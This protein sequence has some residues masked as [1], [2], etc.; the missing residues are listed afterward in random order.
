MS[1]GCQA[2]IAAI[3]LL[4]RDVHIEDVGPEVVC[5]TLCGS[6]SWT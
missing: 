5:L 4:D 1:E 6:P 2:M 3:S